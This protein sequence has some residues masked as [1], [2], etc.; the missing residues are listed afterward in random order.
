MILLYYQVIIID[1]FGLAFLRLMTTLNGMDE[2][3]GSEL[4]LTETT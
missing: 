4:F 1:Y 2:L 3:G